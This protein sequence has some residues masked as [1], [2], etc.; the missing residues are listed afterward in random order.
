[1]NKITQY[2]KDSYKEMRK[3][4]WP[5]KKEII[6]HTLVVI[7]VSLGVATFLGGLD[8]LFNFALEKSLTL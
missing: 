8:Y 1:M 2:F 7:S 4:T 5:T 3:V 6:D